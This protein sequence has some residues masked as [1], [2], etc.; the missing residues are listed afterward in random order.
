VG[1]ICLTEDDRAGSDQFWN[2]NGRDLVYTGL[3][4]N[5]MNAFLAQAKMKANGRMCSNLNIR[6]YKDTILWG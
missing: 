2:K 5:F 1:V 4:I 3:N 6:K